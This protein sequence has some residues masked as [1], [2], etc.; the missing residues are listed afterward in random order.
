M[1]EY[2][3]NSLEKLEKSIAD[4]KAELNNL[5]T[6]GQKPSDELLTKL[7]RDEEQLIAVGKAAEFA[8]LRLIAVQQG[9][10]V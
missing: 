7:Q 6:L 10:S 5:L 1:T 4:T 9:A 2:E 8:A 3:T